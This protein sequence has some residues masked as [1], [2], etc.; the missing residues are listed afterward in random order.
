MIE[1]MKRSQCGRNILL[2]IVNL[3]SIVNKVV[4]KNEKQILFFDS[5][6]DYLDDNT[7]AFFSWLKSNGY[8]KKYKF[9]VCVPKETKKLPFSDYE[10]VGVLKGVIAYMTS[11]YVFF[12]FGDFRIQPSKKQIVVNQWHATPTKKIGKLTYDKNYNREKLDNFTFILSASDTFVPVFSK[13]FGCTQEKVKIIGHARTDYFFSDKDTLSI[14]GIDG[15]AYKKKILWMPTFRT[16]NDNR[17][18]DGNTA[19][20]ETLLPLFSTY[21]SLNRLNVI[22]EKKKMLL[23]IKIHPMACFKKKSYKNIK[24]VTNNDIISQ[25]VRLY[26]F[27]KEFDALVTDYSS[28]YCDYL[29]LDRPIAYTLDDYEKYENSRG[30]VFER[31]IDYMPGHHLY[32]QENMVEFINDI[33]MNSDPYKDDRRKLLSVFCKFVDGKNCERLA[34]AVG[35]SLE[36]ER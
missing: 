31:F 24:I 21:E 7:E 26:E 32:T 9:V 11:K 19:L 33:S 28:I 6:R 29:M 3:L 16:S 22:L 12:S 4:P 2:L 34:K 8:E 13:A 18:H 23:V 30:F 1:R 17:F 5:G 10:P 35:L 15:S 36:E 27:V 14:V 20:S 25:K